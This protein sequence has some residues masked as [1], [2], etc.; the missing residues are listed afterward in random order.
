MLTHP[1]ASGDLELQFLL[2]P[3]CSNYKPVSSWLTCEVLGME[4][5]IS[6]LL[7]LR[8]RALKA[9][10]GPPKSLVLMYSRFQNHPK[11]WLGKKGT[12]QPGTLSITLQIHPNH[13]VFVCSTTHTR[14]CTRAHTLCLFQEK[15][16]EHYAKPCFY[17]S[18]W[19]R[20]PTN[21][22]ETFCKRP[23]Q[24]GLLPRRKLSVKDKA[25]QANC[26]LVSEV[27]QQS[28]VNLGNFQISRSYWHVPFPLRREY[29]WNSKNGKE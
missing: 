9:R 1:I 7:H 6:T 2:L 11:I 12:A 3:K 25:T 19:H 26:S 29:F 24:T 4:L 14:T 28:R 16:E 18:Q 15:Q 22:T 10:K 23:I 27:Q 5:L 17:P 13:P 8:T 21:R 20:P